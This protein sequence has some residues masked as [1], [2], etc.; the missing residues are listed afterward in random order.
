ME[1]CLLAQEGP[2]RPVDVAERLDGGCG[3]AREPSRTRRRDAD[4]KRA[5]NAPARAAAAERRHEAVLSAAKSVFE[6]R[7]WAGSTLREIA[8]R[9]GVSQKTVEAGFGTKGRLL[10]ETVTYAIRGDVEPVQMLRRPGILEME[11]AA[12]A[13]EMLDLHA[14]HLRRVNGRSA[15]IAFIVEQAAQADPEARALWARMNA[16]RLTGVRW[17]TRTLLAKP[18][19][20]GLTAQTAEPIF[21]VAFD[22]STYRTLTGIGG[23]SPARLEGWLK[24]YYGRMLLA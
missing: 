15:Q 12:T 19:L 13:A 11:E 6:D 8:G 7:G 23:L 10:A 21:L 3:C 24:K 16:N 22:W 4:G 9:A 2:E 1:L 17:A 20:G 14:G 5:Y 18:G